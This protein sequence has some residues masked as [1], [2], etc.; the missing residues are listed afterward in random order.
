MARRKA[1]AGPLMLASI[2]LAS[3]ETIARRWWM[4]ATGS[5]SAAEYQRMVVEKLKA[6]QQ[7]SAAALSGDASPAKLFAPWYRA[8]RRNARRLRKNSGWKF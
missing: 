4:M 8:T 2:A 3:S 7:M 1:P 5:C 6:S